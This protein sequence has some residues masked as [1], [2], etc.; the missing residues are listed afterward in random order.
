MRDQALMPTAEKL[1]AAPTLDAWVLT[2]QISPAGT[3]GYRMLGYV[4]G[5]PTIPD[6]WIET[7]RVVDLGAG[8]EWC[9]T[10]AGFYRLLRPLLGSTH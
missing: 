9:G 6:G 3:V 2:E 4:R 8:G 1:A 7:A 10:L 5:H